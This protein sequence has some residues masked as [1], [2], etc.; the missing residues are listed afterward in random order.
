MMLCGC[1]GI[2]GTKAPGVLVVAMAV[3][4]LTKMLLPSRHQSRAV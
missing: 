4:E 2:S 3:V 1:P